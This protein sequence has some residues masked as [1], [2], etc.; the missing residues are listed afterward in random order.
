MLVQFI[1][2]AVW[3]AAPA[4][5]NTHYADPTD[6]IVVQSVQPCHLYGDPDIYGIGIRLSFYLQW[7]SIVVAVFFNETREIIIT[8]RTFNVVALAVLINTYI[9]VTNG[10]LA[11]LEI[12]IVCT[13]VLSLSIYCMIPFGGNREDESPSINPFESKAFHEDPIGIGILLLIDSAFLFS[14]PWLYFVIINQGTKPLCTAR[15]WIFTPIDIY[16]KGWIAALKS[17]SIIGIIAAVLLMSFAVYSIGYGLSVSRTEQRDTEASDCGS[18][19]PSR[20]ETPPSTPTGSTEQRRSTKAVFLA[21]PAMFIAIVLRGIQVLGSRFVLLLLQSF[22]IAFVE[23][24]IRINQIDLSSAPLTATSQLLPFLVGVFS[25]ISV[26]WASVKPYWDGVLTIVR[27]QMR[28]SAA[29]RHFVQAHEDFSTL[30][31]WQ[32]P[33][34]WRHQDITTTS[35]RNVTRTV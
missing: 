5:Q 6:S 3:F 11:A 13:L 30:A 18:R 17:I 29:N 28:D 24:T 12:F 4:L 34:H 7:F 2:S 27:Q 32:V 16:S 35:D 19:S 9:S 15:I 1:L 25:L 23:K 21:L 20:S 22:A 10:S 8:R 33:D 31:Q 26:V 14:Q